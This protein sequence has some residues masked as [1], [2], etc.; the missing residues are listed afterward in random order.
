MNILGINRILVLLHER[1]AK[2]IFGG[3]GITVRERLALDTNQTMPFLIDHRSSRVDVWRRMV[4][5]LY[6]RSHL[7]RVQLQQL[8]RLLRIYVR[9]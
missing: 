9:H 4:A 2:V 1:T 6:E 8:V 7:L 5:V 3:T